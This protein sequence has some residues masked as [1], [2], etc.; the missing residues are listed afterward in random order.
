MKVR[1]S[2]W[3]LPFVTIGCMPLVVP[4]NYHQIQGAVGYQ[5]NAPYEPPCTSPRIATPAMVEEGSLPPGLA[6]EPDGRVYGTPTAPGQWHVMVR[7]PRYQCRSRM[8]ADASRAMHFRIVEAS[9]SSGFPA[10]P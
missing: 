9:R 7:S 6:L 2:L 5:M 10:A 3:A 8:V 1:R 4:L